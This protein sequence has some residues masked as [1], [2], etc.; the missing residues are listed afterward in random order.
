MVQVMV[1]F[2]LQGRVRSLLMNDHDAKDH[3]V[4]LI[5]QHG[6]QSCEHPT[7]N[8][9]AGFAPSV[10]GNFLDMGA[11]GGV[12]SLLCSRLAAGAIVYASAPQAGP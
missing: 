8:L 12:Y 4:G 3:I 5:G 2:D 6:L 7:P 10:G 11:D 1:P 9:V